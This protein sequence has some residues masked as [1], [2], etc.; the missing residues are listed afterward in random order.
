MFCVGSSGVFVR[1]E[2][3]WKAQTSSAVV[4]FTARNLTRTCSAMMV[5][6]ICGHVR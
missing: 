6:T 2:Q 3:S 4:Q 5:N 1:M